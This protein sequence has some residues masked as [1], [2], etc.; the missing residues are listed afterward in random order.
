MLFKKYRVEVSEA[1]EKETQKAVALGYDPEKD[2]APRVVA[3]GKGALAKSIIEIAKQNDVPIYEDESLVAVLSAVDLEAE[4]P[5]ELYAVIAEVFAY[6]YRIQN[7]H[8]VDTQG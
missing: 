6:I 3:S 1:G 7:R 2:S 4:I 5:P 8:F